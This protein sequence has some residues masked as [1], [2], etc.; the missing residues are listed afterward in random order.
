MFVQS[1]E[2]ELITR[3]LCPLVIQ[4]TNEKQLFFCVIVTYL[5]RYAEISLVS[6]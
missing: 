5:D 6:E 1:V 4:T 3:L 2:T